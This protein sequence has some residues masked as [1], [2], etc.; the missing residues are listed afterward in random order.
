[1]LYAK[2]GQT[3]EDEFYSN[4]KIVTYLFAAV[5]YE[6]MQTRVCVC[7]CVCGGGGGVLACACDCVRACASLCVRASMLGLCGLGALSIHYYY[8]SEIQVQEALRQLL[9]PAR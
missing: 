2:D 6:D 7:V 9:R 4:G 3:T 5:F 8:Y 1:M